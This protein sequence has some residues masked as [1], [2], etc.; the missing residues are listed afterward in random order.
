M[1]CDATIRVEVIDRLTGQAVQEG[2]AGV[3]VEVGWPTG[4][5]GLLGGG[6]CVVCGGS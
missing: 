2:L 6:A 3:A 1:Q 4:G 5:G